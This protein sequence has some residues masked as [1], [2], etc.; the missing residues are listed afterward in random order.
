ML[1]RLFGSRAR[2]KILKLFLFNSDERF[3]IRQIARNLDL[4][5]NSARRELENLKGFGLLVSGGKEDT[6][7]KT[8]PKKSQEKYYYVNK[9]FVLF[10]ELRS[11][12]AK[13]QVLYKKD[14]I[15]SIKKAGS[16]QLVV[17]S[18]LFVNNDQ[19][20]VDLLIVGKVEKGKAKKIIEKLEK[21]L[22]AELNFTILS[23]SEFKYRRDITDVFL[24]NVLETRNIV[25]IDKMG[26][27]TEQNKEED[28]EG[29]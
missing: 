19:S 6:G 23:S 11:L 15:E 21:E 1:T 22:G 10:G 29:E 13:A 18:G 24:F 12:I 26:I 3:Y 9:D 27:T 7:E 4:Q 5:V 17:L 28:K 8:S 16:P 2:V 14:F 25:V 20:P